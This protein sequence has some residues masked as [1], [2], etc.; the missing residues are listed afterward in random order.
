MSDRKPSTTNT[1]RF[2]VFLTSK[3]GLAQYWNTGRTLDINE[4]LQA[5]FFV[6][7]SLPLGTFSY[8]T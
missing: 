5:L 2:T 4:N 3:E 6:V 8:T 7:A 1:Y